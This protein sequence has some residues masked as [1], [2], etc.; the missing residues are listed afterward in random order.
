MSAALDD[1]DRL[2]F[3]P[4]DPRQRGGRRAAGRRFETHPRAALPGAGLRPRRAG[5]RWA[6]SAGSGCGCRRRRAA[7]ASAWANGCAL[8]EE[9]GAGLVPEPLIQAALSAGL[10][11]A[12]GE[13]ALL[14]R[15]LAGEALVL[16]AWQERADS[17]DVAG[18]AGRR[19]ALPAAWPAGP[20]LSWFR[21]AKA[22]A[23]RCTASRPPA[24]TWCW[25]RPRTAAPSARCAPTLEGHAPR[26]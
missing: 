21:C 19:A 26:R 24:P 13:K 6:S 11:A 10:L 14:A 20:R 16:T 5:G 17:I 22:T 25:S 23:W 18:S 4:H 9:L 8:V 3:D 2:E 7:R 1:S 15:V 12:A